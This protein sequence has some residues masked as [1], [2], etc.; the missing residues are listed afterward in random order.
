MIAEPMP[1]KAE[2]PKATNF[3]RLFETQRLRLQ[4]IL[5]YDNIILLY[6]NKVNIEIIQNKLTK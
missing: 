2:C 4:I 3:T 6:F 1:V 5:K